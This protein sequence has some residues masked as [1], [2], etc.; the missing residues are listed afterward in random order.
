MSFTHL[1]AGEFMHAY[2]RQVPSIV[3]Q[4]AIR[5][6]MEDARIASVEVAPHS[7]Q[8]F[9]TRHAAVFRCERPPPRA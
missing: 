8:E 9:A 2:F 3:S 7:F 1:R 5:W 4:S 6:P